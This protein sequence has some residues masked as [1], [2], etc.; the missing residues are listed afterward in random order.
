[1]A[2][3]GVFQ[4]FEKFL[5]LAVLLREQLDGV[6]LVPAARAPLAF[7]T[8]AARFAPPGTLLPS[9][10]RRLLD[11][12]TPTGDQL[13]EPAPRFVLVQKCQLVLLESVEEGLPRDLLEGMLTSKPC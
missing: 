2:P 6:R 8:I 12:H 10:L 5:D 4:L 3:L 13:R 7:L 1:G 9:P 11:I